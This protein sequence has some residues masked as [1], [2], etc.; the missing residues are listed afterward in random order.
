[1]RTSLKLMEVEK[2][3]GK[4][5]TRRYFN[6]QEEVK[7]IELLK[8]LYYKEGVKLLSSRML[9]KILG[10]TSVTLRK[11]ARQGKIK[12]VV[13]GDKYKYD[14]SSVI[15]YLSGEGEFIN[16]R[17]RQYKVISI[18]SSS[19]PMGIGDIIE[20]NETVE[21]ILS[22]RRVEHECVVKIKQRI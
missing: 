17:G 22:Q 10:V 15:K 5:K 13:S 3:L 1:M 21:E 2:I 16:V 12:S 11:W 7:V 4:R 14:L 6:G 9:S 20:D 8:V 18:I 19:T